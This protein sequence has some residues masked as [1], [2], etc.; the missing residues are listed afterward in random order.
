MGGELRC[1]QAASPLRVPSALLPG[2]WR[3]PAAPVRP[4]RED[5]C[6]THGTARGPGWG[7]WCRSRF[8]FGN[9]LF[10]RPLCLLATSLCSCGSIYRMHHIE[11]DPPVYVEK[12]QLR[13][14]LPDA[15]SRT[16]NLSSSW[17]GGADFFL[18]QT[19]QQLETRITSFKCGDHATASLP[20]TP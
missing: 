16:Q 20:S 12:L 10:E 6:A 9:D 5:S 2:G 15:P 8:G 18:V 4:L 19:N 17:I 14:V 11:S 13:S 1:P 7:F 3:S